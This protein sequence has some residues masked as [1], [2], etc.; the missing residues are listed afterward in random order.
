[1]R[2]RN[3][4]NTSS[5][6]RIVAAVSLLMLGARNAS[7]AFAQGT[8]APAETKRTNAAKADSGMVLRGD[9]EGSA[10]P[11]LTIEGEDRVHFEFERPQ[12]VL[13]LD[14]LAVP[15]LDLGSTQGVLD[16]TLPDLTTPLLAESRERSSPYLARPWLSNF[17]SGPVA[18]F[19]PQ[20]E[21]V[22][23]WKL[24]VADSRGATV[25]A[26]EGK[27]DPPRE[28]AWDGR[29]A[30]GRG[31]VPG[32]TYSYVFE[33]FDRAGNKRNFVGEGFRLHAYRLTTAKGSTLTFTGADLIV[34]ESGGWSA[35]ASAAPGVTKAAPPLLLE[36]ASWLNQDPGKATP[37]L[38][39]VSARSLDEAER[40]A[41]GV[42]ET[43]AP[44]LLGDPSLIRTVTEV[45]GDAPAEGV[46]QVA[47]QVPGIPASRTGK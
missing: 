38:V 34:E 12:L 30:D 36:A 29:T 5:V 10:L 19:Q 6:I 45:R 4:V 42:A 3:L 44:L 16:R 1:M 39:S 20:V 2:W 41:R 15:G 17:A 37:V 40:L 26:F 9:R 11:S 31:V 27:G 13:E 35:A 43:L 28:I 32:L 18:R 14:P 25:A 22:E 47:R 46:V 33:A 23:R 7:T 8:A 24:M 21:D